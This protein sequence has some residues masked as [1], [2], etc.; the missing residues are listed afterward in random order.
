MNVEQ[1]PFQEE[2]MHLLMEDIIS[3]PDGAELRKWTTMKKKFPAT[4]SKL[5]LTSE[6]YSHV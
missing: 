1:E 5:L 3:K 6:L 2:L 4:V